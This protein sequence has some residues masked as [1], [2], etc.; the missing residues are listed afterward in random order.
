MSNKY[1]QQVYEDDRGIGYGAVD[2]LANICYVSL[3][4][5]GGFIIWISDFNLMALIA[6]LYIPISAMTIY[7]TRLLLRSV[8]AWRDK[9][10]NDLFE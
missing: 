7:I 4:I 2:I 10:A 3:F 1:Y 6:L 5:Y 8:F 9:I